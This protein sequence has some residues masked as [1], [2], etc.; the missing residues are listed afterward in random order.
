[1]N[2]FMRCLYNSYIKPQLDNEALAEC[3]SILDRAEFPQDADLEALFDRVAESY[4]ARAFLLG[5][6]TGAG[7]SGGFK[8]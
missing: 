7:L 5:L 2:D 4:A 1:M 6:R 3:Q 8:N